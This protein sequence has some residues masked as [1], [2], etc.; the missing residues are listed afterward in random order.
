MVMK[1]TETFDSGVRLFV[2]FL[3]KQY[4][5]NWIL[6]HKVFLHVF[7]V[8]RCEYVSYK[9]ELQ[10]FPTVEI[11]E[12]IMEIRILFCLQTDFVWSFV[13][14]AKSFYMKVNKQVSVPLAR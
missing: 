6:I 8:G 13:S 5:C 14:E 4:K 11:F 1:V 10:P 7:S 3:Y 12:N 9:V 2:N